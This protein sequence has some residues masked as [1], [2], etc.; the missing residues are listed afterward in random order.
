[1]LIS[2]LMALIC[3]LRGIRFK[4]RNLSRE[5]ILLIVGKIRVVK[6]MDRDILLVVGENRG[7][8]MEKST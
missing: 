2:S 3:V 6:L 1:M 4:L 5:I 7:K 8:K